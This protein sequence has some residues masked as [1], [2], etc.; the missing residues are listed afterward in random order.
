MKAQ[1][2]SLILTGMLFFVH[3]STAQTEKI[4]AKSFHP[5]G[6]QTLVL[7]L[8]D[9]VE[10]REWDNP[11]VRIQIKIALS[12]S[13]EGLL[14][15]LV[16][17]GRYHLSTVFEEQTVTVAAPRMTVPVQLGNGSKELV[18]Y[19]IFAPRNVAVKID[20]DASKKMVA[21]LNP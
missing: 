10:V 4:F 1:I 7:N 2:V 8:A 11:M 3:S 14:K 9:K 21:R 20:V 6:R 19:L 13:G 18:S 17:T 5:Q 15:A 12:N 16:E